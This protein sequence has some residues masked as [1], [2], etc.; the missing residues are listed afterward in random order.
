MPRKVRNCSTVVG[1]SRFDIASSSA[2]K[3]RAPWRS[4]VMPT[5]STLG[6]QKGD[7]G[8]LTE[9]SLSFRRVGMASRRG[10]CSSKVEVATMMS[11]SQFSTPWSSRSL[12]VVPTRFEKAAGGALRPKP[13]LFRY[14]KRLL[15]SRKAVFCGHLPSLISS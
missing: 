1:Q 15:A 8:R 11:S 2:N 6:V 10:T 5:R 7:L 9:K 14:R 13:A 3:W 4:T 12:R